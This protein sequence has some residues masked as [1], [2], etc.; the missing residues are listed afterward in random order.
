MNLRS[1]V[2]AATLLTPGLA[3]AQMPLPSFEPAQPLSGL[4][5]GAGVGL[6]WLQNEHLIGTQG[7]AVNGAISSNLGM[8]GVASVGYAM[9]YYGFR[10]ELEGD[11]RNNPVNSAHDLGFPAIA[12]GRER[13]YGPMVNVLYDFG[14]LL[15]VPYFAPYVGIG[16]G[17]QWARLSGFHVNGAPTGF[18]GL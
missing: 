5:I 10:M 7:T 6:N 12:G 1:A 16:V 13:K 2:Y 9:P 8:V 18:P 15:P 3:A 17:W 11:L 14:H 4:Y